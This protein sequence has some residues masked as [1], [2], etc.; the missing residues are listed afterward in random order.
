MKNKTNLSS[1]DRSGM[2]HLLMLALLIMVFPVFG[3]EALHAQTY[4]SGVVLD[5]KEEPVVGCMV[6]VK[7]TTNTGTMTD[8]DGRF[9]LEVAEG[10]TLVFSMLGM[11]EVELPSKA[12][13]QVVLKS[14][15]TTLD[16]VV[17]VGY[18][19]QKR[20]SL[21]GAISSVDNDEILTTKSQSLAVS[22]AG[23]VPG[24]R[25]RQTNGQPGA[26]AADI[27][28]RGMGTPM[29]VID[30][31]VRQ[32]TT[33]FQ[34]LNPDD[35]E[36][37]TV[38]KDASA[39][40]YGINSGNGAILVTTK[41][42]KQGPLKVSL[43]ANVGVAAPTAFVDMMNSSQYWEIRNENSYFSTGA[44]Y[45]STKEAL[46]EAQNRPETDWYDEVFKKN[47]IQQSY[48]VSVEGGNEKIQSYTN[49]GYT[50]DNGLL[51]SGDI[52]YSKYSLR[53]GTKYKIT[54]W[55]RMDVSLYGYSDYRKQPGTWD[56]SFFY[57][58]KATHGTIPNETVYANGN[59]EYFNRPRPTNDNPVQNSMS[60]QAG[61]TEYRDKFFQGSMSLTVDIPKVPG[62][63][64]KAR[65]AY[66]GKHTTK[67]KL[68]RLIQS[69]T[70]NAENDTYN[71]FTN[72]TPSLQEESWITQRFDFQGSVNYKNTFGNAHNVAATAVFETRQNDTRYVSAKRFYDG[73]FYTNDNIDRVPSKGMA[74]NGYTSEQ[75][76]VS[77]IGRFNYDYKE[78]YLVELAFREDASYRY[79]P[80]RRWG[81]FPVVSG[82]WRISEEPFVKNNTD[83]LSNLKIRASWGRSG[84]DAGNPFQYVTGYR[85][86]DGYVFSDGSFTNGYVS[87]GLVNPF[88]TWVG[89]ETID[90]GIDLS[91]WN[92][93]LDFSGD[94][95]RRNRDG[96]LGR[97]LGSITNTF[98]ATLPEENLNSDRT[99]GFEI[100]LGHK[101]HRGDFHYG[102]TGNLNFARW[103]VTY[104]E[105]SPFR[106]SWDRWKNAS[107]G[108]YGDIGWGY[109]TIGQY[110]SF[111]EIRNSQVIETGADGMKKTLP[112][113]YKHLDVN[114][115]GKID[116]NDVMPIFWTGAPK[117]TFGL[118][119]YCSW[120]GI[121]FNMLWS[122][123][124]FYTAKYNE[125]LGNVLAFD[126]ANT[127]AMYYD[128]W[129][130]A[131]IYNPDSEW[132]PG[133]YPATRAKDGDNGANRLESN[134]QRVD[135]SHIRLKNVELG[136]TFPKKLLRKAWISNLR[137]Y[138]NLTNPLIICNSYLK[139]FDPEITDGNG[140]QYPI[141]K[142]YNFGINISF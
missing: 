61:Y 59:K 31:V 124:A 55:L 81:F 51:R 135:A 105:R 88:L 126:E 115:N 39:A 107:V 20:A 34:K 76:F 30:G 52:G 80:D 117:M 41:S 112:G 102:I 72:F 131:D 111:D 93:M 136:Y 96:L 95:Y 63:Y 21:T 137:V 89:T 79:H 50:N 92:G 123:A 99:E 1:P 7:G 132:I 74:G 32:E 120:K 57:L 83:I 36:S 121:D 54:D 114:G 133:K 12:K 100:M 104:Q 42:G 48:N 82:G 45:F 98:G 141:Q 85:D 65:V 75:K 128:R 122:G 35:I 73:D 18:G 113:D 38:L 6:Y 138:V 68:Q 129:H 46:A 43:S 109:Q 26:F 134:V 142:S 119:F 29:I 86:A 16:D 90:V 71:K 22:L 58:N 19:T 15:M 9:S 62:L 106:S 66:D 125:I 67:T 139:T 69:Y 101:H 84:E 78:R 108:R 27:N 28:M 3:S 24:L 4:A 11:T 17:V 70:Y 77:V 33:E 127:P 13:M 5:D 87:S 118:T 25:I 14:A 103:M 110:Q 40:I 116:G 56:D 94:I 64:L 140:F 97:R 53:N 49:I 8:M 60:D 91:M 44:P 10:S 2:R 47:S 37:I 23:K 130:K